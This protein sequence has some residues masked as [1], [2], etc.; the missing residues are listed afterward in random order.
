MAAGPQSSSLF[1]PRITLTVPAGWANHADSHG[2]YVLLPPGSHPGAD[3]GAA[4]DWIAFEVNVTFNPEG[5]PPQ[6]AFDEGATAA[7]IANWMAA[8]ANLVTTTPQPVN[9]GGLDGLVLD[10]RLSDNATVECFP[11]PG[12][13][14]VHGLGASDGYDQGI[15]PGVAMRFYFFDH[16]DDVLM[17][18]IDDVSG[19]DRLDEFT[20]VVNTVRFSG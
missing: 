13:F 16:G 1:E 18:E 4:R 2:E 14:L 17:I 3:E 11:R 5:C 6:P 10:V 19:G 7:D 9:V 15:G 8:R 20:T 12:V